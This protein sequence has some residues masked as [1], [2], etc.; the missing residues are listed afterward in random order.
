MD[1]LRRPLLAARQIAVCLLV[2]TTTSIIS[3]SAAKAQ[4][5]TTYSARTDRLLQPE[6]PM[7]PPAVNAVFQDPDFG[8]YM[9]R[10]TD[11]NTNPSSPGLFYRN[12]SVGDQN[13]WAIDDSK[14]YI[15][16]QNG[17]MKFFSFD[18]AAMQVT[19]L[20]NIPL[21]SEAEF[22]F[23]D[24]DLIYGVSSA[25]PYVIRSYRFS[26]GVTS[27][28]FDT[29]T[30]GAQPALS[31]TGTSGTISVSAQDARFAMIEGGPRSD[32]HMFVA[33]YD[34]VLGCEWYN[35]QTG[36]VGGQ[37]GPTGAATVIPPYTIR[38]GVISRD[39]NNVF[40]L[41]NASGAIEYI[42]Q[43]GTLN[44]TTC[45]SHTD[46]CGGYESIG[47]SH[48]M[49][50][51]GVTDEMNPWLR[52]LDNISDTEQ[53][54]IPLKT[55]HKFGMVQRWA[56][57]NADPLDSVPIC[58]TTF[59]Y[60]TFDAIETVWDSE[61]DC[62]ETDGLAWTVWR[63]CHN[64]SAVSSSYFNTQPLGNISYDGHYFLFTTDWDNL[65]GI[66]ANGN[67]RSDVFI[68]QME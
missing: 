67:P 32:T 59:R 51:T 2:V 18:P 68:V 52:P 38:G 29:N 9:V 14:F 8:S 57:T 43:I 64:R 4:A 23:A 24:P 58:G 46:H 42:W 66:Q 40:I 13:T 54:V 33:V 37:W 36:Q 19:L 21:R 10:V 34:P 20:N 50:S 30:C 49:N 25:T 5:A 6:T 45:S 65:L 16:A 55:P 12:A 11:T 41:S 63:M 60:N 44:V 47:Y 26:T 39:G 17:L 7:A 61:V 53:L 62:I 35:T 22:S 31:S 28:V 3:P 15:V 27:A 1:T 56:W 48:M